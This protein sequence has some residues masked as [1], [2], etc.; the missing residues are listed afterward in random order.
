MKNLLF[1]TVLIAL[2]F[3]FPALAADDGHGHEEAGH[4]EAS[5]VEEKHEEAEHEE[6]G[7]SHEDHGEE[8][9]HDE[10][11]DGHGDHGSEEGGHEEEEESGAVDLTPESMKEAGIL[12]EP[13]TLQNLEAEV[14]APGEV[15]LNSYLSSKVTP[16]IEAQIV[17]RY[18]KL[19]DTVEKGQPLVTLSGV[20]MAEAIGELMVAHKEWRRVQQLGSSAVSAKRYSE[21]K[22]ADEQATAK[23]MAYGMTEAQIKVLHEKGSG[24]SPGSFQLVAPQGGTIVSDDFIEGELI[25]PGRV[26]FN[27]VNEDSLWVESRLS[28]ERAKEVEVGAGARVHIPGNGWLQGT[29]VQKHH[30]LDEETR[31]IGVRIEVDNEEDRLH[32]GM[33]VDTKIQSGSDQKYLAVPTASVLRSPDGDWVVFVEAKPG[34]FKPQEVKTLRTVEDYTVIDSLPEGTRVVTEG[35]FF[36]QSELAKSGFS[37]HNH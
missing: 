25:E 18:A 4:K 19:G 21:A 23:V 1:L 9:N 2:S 35:A 10:K 28:P 36:V 30:L 20:D 6:H 22:I 24:G 15:K 34:E 16:R 11:E 13:L 32:P 7:D 12:V 27:I 17:A 26:L 31:T 33:Y 29:V 14:K 3:Q 37:V 5:P 8:K